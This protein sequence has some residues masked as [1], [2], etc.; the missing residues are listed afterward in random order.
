MAIDAKTSVSNFTQTIR[1][2]L[3]VV[4]Q[5]ALLSTDTK[6]ARMVGAYLE[7]MEGK[8]KAGQERA[9]GAGAFA[10][11][12]FEADVFRRFV[13]ITAEQQLLL[14][15]FLAHAAPSQ[16]EF[17]NATMDNDVSRTVETMRKVGLD[18]IVTGS[19]AGVGG[20]D[21][22]GAATARINLLKRVE[23]RMADDLSALTNDVHG[24]AKAVLTTT[25]FGVLAAML[26]AV[27]VAWAVV[28]QMTASIASMVTIMRRL[29]TDDFSVT[30]SGT[31]RRDEMG[32][33][34]RSVQVFKDAMMRGQDLA[35][36][37]LADAK[38]RE[39]RA[40][41]IEQLVQ[42]FQQVTGDM[43]R[44]V[45]NA[46]E[47]LQGTAAVMNAASNDANHRAATVAAAAE[48]A[49]TNVQTVASAAEELTCSIQE[50]GRQVQR[51]SEISGNAVD[52]AN[53]AQHTVTSLSQMVS[54]ISDVATLI[55]DIAAHTN[56]LALN[57]TIEAARAGDAGKGFAVVASEV[58]NLSNQTAKATDEIGQQI[59]AVQQQTQK[60]V[61]AI[62]GIVEIIREVGQ[63]TAGIA[64]AVEQQSAATQEIARSVVTA[65]HGTADVSHNVAGVQDAADRTGQAA[66][67]VLTSSEQMGR[68]A[69]SL[70]SAIERFR[71]ELLAV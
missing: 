17:Y 11:G 56:L 16:V 35:E 70:Q 50:I 7:L 21:W 40:I 43:V 37:H 20:P 27:A 42:R 71:G 14:K 33:M 58:K 59:N 30:V 64:S 8:E 22:F 24:N 45:A 51:S 44:S 26:L 10:S 29:S 47:R 23:D 18:S 67:D 39:E 68:Q 32:E 13:A 31:E 9:V 25:I 12:S 1:L 15:Q 57:A 63:L 4:D 34:A 19:T 62:A 49:S 5:I 3:D 66:A 46:A 36:R 61:H 65:S 69:H 55:N 41:A 6:V 38:H 60:V 28:R 52:E 48:L 53:E 2:H 54:R